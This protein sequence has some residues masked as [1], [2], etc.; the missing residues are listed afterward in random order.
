MANRNGVALPAL[1]YLHCS[2]SRI[3]TATQHYNSR[4]NV[5]ERVFWHSIVHARRDAKMSLERF[6]T[7]ES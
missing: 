3:R 7:S 4:T 6:A 1:E 5:G 2:S